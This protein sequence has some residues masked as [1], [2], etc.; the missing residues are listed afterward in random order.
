MGVGDVAHA[1][2][3]QLT[4]R[5][6]RFWGRRV[7]ER[8]GRQEYLLSLALEG[9]M[10]LRLVER[11]D[12]HVG[13]FL[14]RLI[15]ELRDFPCPNAPAMELAQRSRHVLPSALQN[16]QVILLSAEL[17]AGVVLLQRKVRGEEDP[18]QALDDREPDWRERLP[19]D[20]HHKTAEK[21]LRSLIQAAREVSTNQR[22]LNVTTRLLPWNQGYR[23][24]RAITLPRKL[25]HSWL[26]QLLTQQE[27]PA[28][29][30]LISLA[31]D[32]TRQPLAMLT[33]RSSTEYLVETTHGA[34]ARL[35]GDS[36]LGPV[37]LSAWSGGQEL[38]RYVLPRGEELGMLPWLFVPDLQAKE[39]GT[40]RLAGTGSGRFRVSEVLLALPEG[41]H[42]TVRVP[43][44]RWERL[45]QLVGGRE[46][47][48]LQG[49]VQVALADMGV[50]QVDT[51][52]DS[53]ET[54]QCRLETEAQELLPGVVAYLGVPA[55]RVRFATG[56]EQRRDSRELDYRPM[57]AKTWRRVDGACVGDVSLRYL[58]GGALLFQTR[59]RIL[60]PGASL[61]AQPEGARQGRLCLRALGGASVKVPPA[62]HV[63]ADVQ[64]S[65]ADTE[66]LLRCDG[67]AP[68]FAS[69][70]VAWPG[71]QACSLQVPFPRQLVGFT[72][73]SARPLRDGTLVP[74]DRLGRVRAFVRTSHL[75]ASAVLEVAP[76]GTAQ[77]LDPFFRLKIP[78]RC[79]APGTL[80]L[81]LGEIE[82]ALAKRLAS[83]G[84]LDALYELR[85]RIRGGSESRP[86]LL[87]VGRYDLTLSPEWRMSQVRLAETDMAGMNGGAALAVEIRPL[88]H[89]VT[90]ERELERVAP[91]TWLIPSDLAPGPWL[92]TGREG[93]W[94]RGRPLLWNVCSEGGGSEVPVL[95]PLQRAVCAP[96]QRRKA[97]LDAA[98]EALGSDANHP[99]WPT[100]LAYL[101]SLGELP[102]ETFDAVRQLV[103]HPQTAVLAL[104]L[105]SE[106]DR[107]RI[108]V[109]LEELPFQWPLVSARAWMDATRS[110]LDSA[111]HL[112]PDLRATVEPMLHTRHGEVCKMAQSHFAGLEAV[113]QW[114]KGRMA[115]S[116]SRS[117]TQTP[118]NG[119]PGV[120]MAL[121]PVLEGE[122]HQL[123]RLHAD[124]PWPSVSNYYASIEEPLRG[125]PPTAQ[126]HVFRP[127]QDIEESLP[128]LNAPVLAALAVVHDQRLSAATRFTL[129]TLREAHPTWFSFAFGYVASVCL[130]EVK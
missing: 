105:L 65:G 22:E 66:I 26:S 107:S 125:F 96:P 51:G 95:G 11:P 110:W 75:Q 45:G 58:S 27:L 91:G 50:C 130:G 34:S 36:W 108:W 4:E 72:D 104:F 111:S 19:L 62:P 31:S 92:V 100:L 70:D 60:P 32:G 122:L 63:H 5:G 129:R 86:P 121:R 79:T 9:G 116:S 49:C 124:A 57:G 3:A 59:L 117:G 46:V 25:S 126:R 39:E 42:L 48:R 94:Y 6:L 23:L 21:L 101:R 118:P 93:N 78:L 127:L 115:S 44:A 67:E 80:E 128:L 40:W 71:G 61:R 77:S 120:A 12:T 13:R 16:E 87:R 43:G 76:G 112:S 114:V 52:S 1:Q 102:P 17:A 2:L 29:L 15:Q 55:L 47:F 28:R 119:S 54:Q 30:Q 10:P 103:D 56:F 20:M 84:D 68:D 18:Y 98:L 97:E 85:L 74:L 24:E 69:I 89:P 14:L 113:L 88:V 64:V 90:P 41:A 38:G 7:V 109:G 123:R 33:Q 99:D 73:T 53:E 83:F 8:S 81:N 37:L 82:S 35:S 106:P